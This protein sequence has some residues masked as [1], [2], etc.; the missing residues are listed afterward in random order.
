[1]CKREWIHVFGY[2]ELPRLGSARQG[3]KRSGNQ[4]GLQFRERNRRAKDIPKAQHAESEGRPSQPDTTGP[5]VY[6]LQWTR[7]VVTPRWGYS[8]VGLP[9]TTAEQLF[10]LADQLLEGL[11]FLHEKRIAHRDIAPQNTVLN[12]LFERGTRHDPNDIR[13]PSNAR[14][15]FIDFDASSIFPM[16][17][18][19]Q[20][21]VQD[22]EMRIGAHI[23][24]LE[25]GKSNPFTD[26]V[27]I[28]VD[29]L[30]YPVRVL[31]RAIPEIG[32]FF[33]EILKNKAG[34]NFRITAVSV[35]EEL[36]RIRSKLTQ[37]QLNQLPEG[38]LW[39]DGHIQPRK[40][41]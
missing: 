19:I 30:Q 22:R 34:P 36:R 15:A 32:P 24:D 12:S 23:L 11:V 38:R 33:D 31:E 14:Y 37:E 3:R 16:E 13:G 17:T 26:D 10:I 18:D 2:S 35:L 5:R 6:H 20:T 27:L 4:D 41:R 40:D 9:F 28:L 1:M 29:T 7:F 8:F 39:Q 25:E 21:V